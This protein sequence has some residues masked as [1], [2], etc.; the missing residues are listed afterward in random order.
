MIS[1]REKQ[2]FVDLLIYAFVGC[3]LYVPWPGIEPATLVY[4]DD[5]LTNWAP[6]PVPVAGDSDIPSLK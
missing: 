3:F 4:Q 1:E 2:Q 6:W 5:V